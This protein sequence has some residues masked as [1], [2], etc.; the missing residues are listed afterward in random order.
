MLGAAKKK[1][2]ENDKNL[3]ELRQIRDESIGKINDKT[4]AFKSALK[5]FLYISNKLSQDF[6]DSKII[7]DRLKQ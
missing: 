3:A 1:I 2:E 7:V 4:T 6:P 5:S